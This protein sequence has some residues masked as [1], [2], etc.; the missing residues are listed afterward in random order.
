MA[1]QRSTASFRRQGSSGLIWNDRFLSGEIR[2]DERQEDRCNDHRD[3]PMAAAAATVQRSASDGGR[4]HVGGRLVDMS[5]TLDPPSPKISVG[6]G[7]CS[8]FSSNRRRRSR[9]RRRSS[10]GST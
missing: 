5:P 2:N 9:G 1:L 3:G 6:C 4:G 8:L 10:C 7:F